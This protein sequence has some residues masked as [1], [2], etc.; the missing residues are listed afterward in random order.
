MLRWTF[1]F[2]LQSHTGILK[3]IIFLT[4]I[5]F[6]LLSS[7]KKLDLY[8]SHCVR[9]DDFSAWPMGEISVDLFNFTLIF[10]GNDD[11]AG[12]RITWLFYLQEVFFPA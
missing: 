9:M 5:F 4:K 6:F 7:G 8:Q 11:S 12:E 2:I 1:K 3:H 10:H